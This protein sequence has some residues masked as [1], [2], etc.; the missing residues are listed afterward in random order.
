VRH[1]SRS[2]VKFIYIYI[3]EG[4]YDRLERWWLLRK[5]ERWVQ[6]CA[7]HIYIGRATNI[8]GSPKASVNDAKRSVHYQIIQMISWLKPTTQLRYKFQILPT[9]PRLCNSF[10]ADGATRI[11]FVFVC[12]IYIS[13]Q[14]VMCRIQVVSSHE[15]KII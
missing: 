1:E 3:I 13:V 6:K 8:Y 4:S 7:S 14:S 10:R 12:R 11:Q 5:R 15:Y 9:P 2:S